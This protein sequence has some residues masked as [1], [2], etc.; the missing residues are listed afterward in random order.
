MPVCWKC[1]RM[2][3]TAEIRRSPK[4]GVCKSKTQCAIRVRDNRRKEKGK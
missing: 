1:G 2:D 3:S 4:G